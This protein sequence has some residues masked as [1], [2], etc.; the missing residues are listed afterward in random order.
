[1]VVLADGAAAPTH[2]DL[3]AHCTAPR[4]ARPKIPEGIEVGDRLP[5]NATGKV[6]KQDLVDRYA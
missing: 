1:V 3:T 2:A 6:L 5:R 4:L